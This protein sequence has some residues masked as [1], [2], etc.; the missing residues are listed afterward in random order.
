VIHQIVAYW[1]Y[2]NLNIRNNPGTIG[3]K[4]ISKITPPGDISSQINLDV[5]EVTEETETIEGKTDRWL[6]IIY[7]GVEGW[8]FGGYTSVERGGPKYFTPEYII[9]F[10]LG[11]Y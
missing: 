6:K 2:D 4:V 9:A 7:N 5:L 1:G 8:I 11:W 10:E 3:T